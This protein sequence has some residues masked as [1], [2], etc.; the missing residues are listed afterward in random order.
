[1]SD[2]TPTEA[3]LAREGGGKAGGVM[4]ADPKQGTWRAM[5]RQV[6][7]ETLDAIPTTATEKECRAALRLVYPFGQRHFHP[8]KV[9]C[10]E[11]RRGLKARFG[12]KMAKEAATKVVAPFGE[13]LVRCTW[14]KD[15][16]GCVASTPELV[17]TLPTPTNRY[18]G[19]F[20]IPRRCRRCWICWTS[21]TG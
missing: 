12:R 1:M 9:W 13:L 20:S 16:A 4:A 18:R 2:I 7:R 6:V 10:E 15:K 19:C 3:D 14:C 11:V 8:Y 21:G 5:A 17:L